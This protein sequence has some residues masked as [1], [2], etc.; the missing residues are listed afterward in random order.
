MT[1]AVAAHAPKRGRR[2]S[3]IVSLVAA[4]LGV[5]ALPLA[6]VAYQVHLSRESMV[7]QA[8]RTHLIAARATADRVQSALSSVQAV[9]DGAARN[10]HLY[11]APGS[12]ESSEVLAG[13]LMT[14]VS[15]QAAALFHTEGGRDTL[16]QLAR[17]PGATDI[18][19]DALAALGPNVRLQRDGE[20]LRWGLS[21]DTGRPGLRLAVFADASALADLLLPRELGPSAQLVLL[22]SATAHP[23]LGSTVHLPDALLQA[24]PQSRLD[25]LAVRSEGDSGIEVA[26]FARIAGTDWAIASLQPAS[27]AETAAARMRRGAFAASAAVLALIVVLSVFAWRRVVRPVRAL[28]DY[29][30]S[31]LASESADDSDLSSLR[32]AFEQIQRNQRNREALGEVFVGRYRLLSTLGQGA[33]GSV[34]LAWDP[35]LQ[36]HVAIKTLHLDA[37]DAHQQAS[38]AEALSAEAVKVAKLQHQSIVGVHDLVAAGEFVFVVMEYVEGGNLRGLIDQQGALE[39]AEIVLIARAMLGALHVAHRSGLLHLDIKPGNL[40]VS[41]EGE[42]KLADFGVSAWRSELP[43]LLSREGAAGTPGFIAPEYLDGEAPSERSDLFS[44]G[45]VLVECMTGVRQSLPGARTGDLLRA[46][47]L[48]RAPPAAARRESVAL[49]MAVQALCHVDPA[50]RPASASAALEMFAQMDVDGARERLAGRVRT[51]AAKGVRPRSE[52]ATRARDL[53]TTQPM[54][55]L[56]P[57]VADAEAAEPTRRQPWAEATQAQPWAEETRAQP[58]AEATRPQPWVDHA[59]VDAGRSK[60]DSALASTDASAA[61]GSDEATRKHPPVRSDRSALDDTTQP[62]ARSPDPQRNPGSSHETKGPS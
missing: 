28:L 52:V 1:S 36:R 61:I 27:E 50:L 6:L 26:A 9:V 53:A 56:A 49:W 48:R 46:A 13:L 54:R 17:I 25:A 10:P 30:R 45:V 5:A 37:L 57:A 18:G 35:S 59:Q 21:R 22:Q 12:P 58:W 44:L 34:F 11:Q 40:L 60:T 42:V 8:Q 14:E 51:M 47:R 2:N 31:A 23:V 41:P 39:P 33:M 32:Q 29:Q 62:A 43:E 16:V 55:V 15:L 38:L 3:L 24:L 20:A 4:L 7:E 19:A